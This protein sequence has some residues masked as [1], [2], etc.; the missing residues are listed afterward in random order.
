MST[1]HKHIT[2]VQGHPD[3]RGGHFCHA[4]ADAY[5]K[6][7]A[8]SGHEVERIDVATLDFP[9]LRSK[10]DFEAG[11]TPAAIRGAQAPIARAEHLV[12]I[13]PLWQG[14]L[15]ALVKGF[16]EQTFRPE[17][18]FGGRKPRGFWEAVK[19]PDKPLR[20]K[21]AR[22]IVTMMMP[23]IAARILRRWVPERQVLGISGVRPIRES[24]VGLVDGPDSTRRMRWLDRVQALG[25]KAA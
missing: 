21:T 3:P 24:L 8:E 23:G 22:I 1:V 9:L 16:L 12:L 10:A 2:I 20:G 6:G 7:A 5:A 11:A 15:P 13:Y 18:I 17:F 4:I 19:A 25:R 14:A